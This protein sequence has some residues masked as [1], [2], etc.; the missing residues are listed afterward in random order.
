MTFIAVHVE[1]ACQ[2]SRS[3]PSFSSPQHFQKRVRAETT[4]REQIGPFVS[5]RD[6]GKSAMQA[7]G[8]DR[9]GF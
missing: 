3:Q 2:T 5:A 6:L 7:P 1:T 8:I 4:Y 9:L